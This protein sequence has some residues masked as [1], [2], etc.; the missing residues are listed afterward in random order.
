MLKQTFDIGDQVTYKHPLDD[1]F[2][3]VNATIPG[4]VIE[5]DTALDLVKVS[6]RLG[7]LGNPRIVETWANPDHLESK[8][9][10]ADPDRL[11]RQLAAAEKIAAKDWNSYIFDEHS[12]KFF[13]SFEELFEEYEYEDEDEWDIP[14]WAWATKGKVIKIDDAINLIESKIDDLVADEVYEADDFVGIE[15]LQQAIDTFNQLN[16]TKIIYNP[17]CSKAIIFSED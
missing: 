7:T 11:T 16:Q 10:I 13:A 15:E 14:S 17:D 4:K 1:I 2:E 12:D 3:G 6:F 5:L 9:H 8:M